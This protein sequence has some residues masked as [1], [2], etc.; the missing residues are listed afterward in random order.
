M[1]PD[2]LV[3]RVALRFLFLVLDSIAPFSL[4]WTVA[5]IWLWPVHPLVV[6]WPIDHFDLLLRHDFYLP[7][8][9]T[10]WCIV[11]STWWFFHT[12]G[13]QLV[14]RGYWDLREAKQPLEAE[15]RWRL[16]V[17]MLESCQDPW[18]W[19]GGAFLAP[20]ARVAPLGMDDPAIAR[21]RIQDVGR[22]N[23]EQFVAHFMF[24]QKLRLVQPGSIERLEINAMIKLLEIALGRT[25]G[26][27]FKF[28]KGRSRHRVFL[29]NDQPILT[30]HHPAIFYVSIWFA[31]EMGNIALWL[32]GFKYYG[33]KRSWPF[34]FFFMRG[35]RQQLDALHDPS[36]LDAM[37]RSTNSELAN[38]VGYWF[39]PGSQKAQEEG[40]T[41]ILFFHGISGTYGPT[42]FILYLQYI[43]GRPLLL[44]EFPYVTMRLSPPS[45]IRTRVETVA[46]ARRAL[47]RHGFGLAN[48]TSD[49]LNANN[50]DDED[51][52][53]DWRR[54][55]CVVVGHSLG[56]GTSGWILRDA[57]DIVAGMVL[58]DP[59]SI[60]LFAA[61]GPRNFVRTKVRTAGQIFFKYFALE[62]GIKH[63]LSRHLRWTDSVIFGPNP[64]SALPEEVKR[65]I[66]PR[67][68]RTEIQVP[69]DRPNYAQWIS[70]C[71]KGPIPSQVFLSEGDC[72]LNVPGKLA[73]YLRGSGFEEGKNLYIMP[74]EHAAV[75]ISP[76]WCRKIAQAVTEV[77]DAGEKVLYE[78]LEEEEAQVATVGNGST[79]L[80]RDKKDVE[81][82]Q[83]E[84]AK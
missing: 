34:P 72:I 5:S 62:R 24:N 83:V 61:D 22:S 16:W 65:A 31:S 32:G 77:A 59:M 7:N 50:D 67:V 63:L 9:V 1:F 19:L 64:I 41:P 78:F 20:G 57:P 28:L 42:P 66:V 53:E 73:P 68:A 44:P 26:G 40:L 79:G 3:I 38:R 8:I 4:A 17:K 23:I 69:F 14:A 30:S 10:G 74:G 39:H 54:A 27:E 71:P 84:E 80:G 55:R 13:R 76:Y 2:L 81:K 6:L 33:P 18:E 60:M 51:D 25:R 56:G 15:E 70:A 49:S 45:A 21:V 12:I 52:E 36:E 48:G 47:W 37:D 82:Q 46:M 43:T 58:I 35:S 29:V 75:L 11:E